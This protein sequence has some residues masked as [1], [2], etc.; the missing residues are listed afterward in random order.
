MEKPPTIKSKRVGL[1]SKEEIPFDLD[2]GILIG[3]GTYGNVYKYENISYKPR[4]GKIYNAVAIKFSSYVSNILDSSTIVEIGMLAGIESDYIIELLDVI[5]DNKQIGLILPLGSKSLE[6]LLKKGG[7]K[8][9]K[10][11]I[12]D[13]WDL[14]YQVIRSAAVL[15]SLCI[16]HGDYKP[17][18]YLVMSNED[19]PF[20]IVISDFGLAKLCECYSYD[21]IKEVFT[22]MYRSPELLFQEGQIYEP[23]ADSWS[24]G[25]IIY[26]I[27]TRQPLFY[28]YDEYTT[29]YTIRDI[30]V[31]RYGYP[32]EFT[33]IDEELEKEL[34]KID[35]KNRQ[36]KEEGR[37][38]SVDIETYLR[39]TIPEEFKIIIPLLVSLLQLYPKNRLLISSLNKDIETNKVIKPLLEA[40][41]R[42]ER[43]RSK[44]RL[45]RHCTTK[46]TKRQFDIPTLKVDLELYL[47][48][49]INLYITLQLEDNIFFRWI[50][51]FQIFLTKYYSEKNRE[52]TREELMNTLYASLSLA[53][54]LGVYFTS[55]IGVK[56]FVF[57]SKLFLTALLQVF[58]ELNFDIFRSTS[59]DFIYYYSEK[60]KEIDVDIC[61]KYLYLS[62][63][64]SISTRG[65][66]KD[67]ADTIIDLTLT[68]TNKESKYK[69]ENT[70]KLLNV[71]EQDLVGLSP[72]KKKKILNIFTDVYIDLLKGIPKVYQSFKPYLP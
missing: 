55:E 48:E 60:D 24:I 66:P 23:E 4:N 16:L 7:T 15:E 59:Y 58:A 64:S 28:E 10:L 41:D 25:C 44:N 43:N 47:N 33:E 21:R 45:S 31:K 19:E 20:T 3:K 36:N 9:R 12:E 13:K 11:S 46:L 38:Y 61:I 34:K 68:Y 50:S 32:N 71:F 56:D 18:N 14:I 6:T 29:D 17:Q 22:V 42:V 35:K 51:I 30:V 63:L 26:E 5:I 2:K 1:L 72:N 53:S 52:Q 27:I 49:I 69:S 65:D 57:D 8:I 37:K 40:R 54:V 39:R 70:I 67:I 62:Y